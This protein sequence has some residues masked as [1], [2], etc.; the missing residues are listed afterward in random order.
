[1]SSFF[2]MLRV[3]WGESISKACYRS[4]VCGWRN[5]HPPAG[6]QKVIVINKRKLVDQI[7]IMPCQIGSNGRV[8]IPNIANC[9]M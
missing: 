4:R 7:M 9:L 2:F 5:R 3:P 1:M 6:Q 8:N